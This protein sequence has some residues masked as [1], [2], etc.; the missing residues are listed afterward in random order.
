MVSKNIIKKT[1]DNIL[2]KHGV[3]KNEYGYYLNC[4]NKNEKKEIMKRLHDNKIISTE[5]YNN[6]L[7]SLK[8]GDDT[9]IFKYE[10][11][12]VNH[13]KKWKL[14]YK[15]GNY[16]LEV[17]PVLKSETYLQKLNSAKKSRPLDD[18]WRVSIP[19]EQRLK[20]NVKMYKCKN[21]SVFAID[22]D[23]DIMAVCRKLNNNH[24][25][26]N[27]YLM[28]DFA[29]NHGG[30]KLD[31]FDGNWK[32]YITCGFEPRTYIE[33][34][35]DALEKDG[36]KYYDNNP[37]FNKENVVFFEYTGKKSKYNK[38]EDFY[39]VIKPIR[40]YTSPRDNVYDEAWYQRDNMM[41]N[42]N[43]K[44]D[45]IVIK[46]EETKKYPVSEEEYIYAVQ[47]YFKR[48]YPM[49]SN[50]FDM[51]YDEKVIKLIKEGYKTDCWKYDNGQTQGD[52]FNINNPILGNSILPALELAVEFP[53]YLD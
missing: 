14:I 9:K 3:T 35:Y 16:E 37:D 5:N 32:Y 10:Q 8:K 31:S 12:I 24:I 22:N 15:K 27:P 23:G 38:P 28:M 29:T 41:K 46:K 47:E 40:N 43:K 36:Q 50:Y 13:R 20:E 45:N 17:K 11:E 30:T 7:E 34:N 26:D 25:N 51:L 42:K 4:L 39:K 49:L 53:E 18:A 48:T 52:Y 19:S 21:G 33:F 1:I 2:I 6:Y 44:L